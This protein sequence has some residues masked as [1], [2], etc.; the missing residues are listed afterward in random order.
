MKS[1]ALI[2]IAAVATAV[3]LDAEFVERQAW[4]AP[5]G[6]NAVGAYIQS[7]L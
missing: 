2:L 7:S 1:F 4:D 6:A 5:V 3:S